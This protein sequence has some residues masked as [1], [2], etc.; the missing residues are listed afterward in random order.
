MALTTEEREQYF[1]DNGCYPIEDSDVPDN[2]KIILTAEQ[3]AFGEAI[4]KKLNA[5]KYLKDTDWY[6]IR[7]ADSGKDIP[8][9]IKTKRAQARLDASEE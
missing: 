9:D 1:I 5:I 2:E 6:A 8:T 4:T 3:I 7:K